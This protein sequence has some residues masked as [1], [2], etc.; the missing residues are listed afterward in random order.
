M[1]KEKN[2]IILS[3]IPPGAS[4]VGRVLEFLTRNLPNR[5]IYFPPSLKSGISTRASMLEFNLFHLLIRVYEKF[6]IRLNQLVLELKIWLWWNKEIVLIHPQS[7]GY[8]NVKRL[9]SRNDVSIYIM[10]NSFFCIKSYNYIDGEKEE[11]LRCL[12]LNYSSSIHNGCK[13]FPLKIENS[14]YFKF[15][16]F[17]NQKKERIQFLYQNTNQ[18]RLLHRQFGE[19]IISKQV[20]LATSDMFEVYESK[21]LT[22]PYEYDFIFHGDN[23]AAKGFH[24][25]LQLARELPQYSF[26]FPCKN[27]LDLNLQNA[28]FQPMRWDEGLKDSLIKSRIVICPSLW[29][30]PIEGSLVKSLLLGK[31]VVVVEGKYNYANELPDTAVIKLTGNLLYDVKTLK[32]IINEHKLKEFGEKGKKFITQ[33]LL[34]YSNLMSK[35]L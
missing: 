4:G 34:S 35:N 1:R 17:L 30:A 24:Y 22:L 6:S 11:C 26:L 7:I 28:I 29:S 20:G 13:S 32:K 25:A 8:K 16:E 31:A 33:K 18:L 15:L 10:D 3:G 12:N 21:K 2:K 27:D 5:K 23:I 14:E 9:I 19:E